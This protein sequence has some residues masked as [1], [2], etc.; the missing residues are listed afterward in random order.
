[1]VK[2]DIDFLPM[3]SP[4]LKFIGWHKPAIELIADE[5]FALQQSEP[6]D[7]CRATVVVPTAASKRR[8]KEYMAE[9]AKGQAL[10][11]PEITLVSSLLSG[12]EAKAATELETQS[13]WLWVLLNL[14]KTE[15]TEEKLAS[16][17]SPWAP[18]FPVAPKG[19]LL[20]W[21]ET[22]ATQLRTFR[23]RLEQEMVADAYGE[24]LQNLARRSQL[25]NEEKWQH[26]FEK[27]GE[28]RELIQ[29]LFTL[30]D[31]R[32]HTTTE[33]WTQEEARAALLKAP[34]YKSKLIIFACV[35]EVSPQT[36]AF[37]T[38]LAAAGTKIV[39]WVNADDSVQA[40][41]DRFGQP[42]LTLTEEEK[43]EGKDTPYWLREAIEI[44]NALNSTHP[45]LHVTQDARTLGLETVKLA[46]GLSPEQVSVISCDESM[47][48][49]LSAAFADGAD[50][51]AWTVFAPAG[52]QQNAAAAACLP[53]QLL[54]AVQAQQALPLYYEET[55][56]L[57]N[58][59]PAPLSEFEPLLRNKLMQWCF[60]AT[61]HYIEPLREVPTDFIPIHM[62]YCLDKVC[63]KLL[64]ASLQE[65]ERQLGN[66]YRMARYAD[67]KGSL[68]NESYK[69]FVQWVA[70]YLSALAAPES[71]IPGIEKLIQ[72][73]FRVSQTEIAP[74]EIKIQ[75][76]KL[77]THLYAVKKH[78]SAVALPPLTALALLLHLVRHEAQHSVQPI[79]PK[80]E[81][82]LDIPDWKEAAYTRGDRLI[83]TGM[84]NHTV[85]E[86]P[87][88]DAYLPESLRCEIGMTSARSREA[89]DAFLLTALL[90]SRAAGEVH[91]VLAHQQ[92]DGTP[93]APST[94]LLRCGEHHEELAQRA[95]YLFGEVP[96][97]PPADLYEKWVP[98]TSSP[99][100]GEKETIEMLGKTRED[101]PYSSPQKTFSPSAINTFLNCPLRFW[102]KEL[103]SLSPSDTY[104][105]DKVDLDAREYG[106]EMHDVLQ[107][108]VEKYRSA[109]DIK[110]KLPPLSLTHATLYEVQDRLGD[111][112]ER[113]ITEALHKKF[114]QPLSFPLKAQLDLLCA[115]LRYVAALHAKDL[116]DGWVNVF[117]EL[118]LTPELPLEGDEPPARF[119]MKADR[120]DYN[121]LTN[122]WRIIDY[123]SNDKAPDKTHYAKID[124]ESAYVELMETEALLMAEEDK[125][126]NAKDT[127]YRWTNLQLPLYAYGL[128]CL[129]QG[130]PTEKKSREAWDEAQQRCPEILATLT[131][132]VLPELCY[133]N[134]PKN[135]IDATL[136][137]LHS[138]RK[139][140]NSFP[141][142]MREDGLDNALKWV[143]KLCLMMRRGEC[144]YSA[145]SLGI[146]AKGGDFE[147]L[148]PSQDPRS[149]CGL[150]VS[151]KQH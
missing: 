31:E 9:T 38:A 32:I 90:H 42:L 70:K 75:A 11:M 41:F 29:T 127:F 151:S 17:D 126:G 20:S 95:A 145:E 64:P 120:I 21:A 12:N 92:A 25:N 49:A 147:N 149:M 150:P 83:I 33:K 103:F 72:A 84:H 76:K 40:C 143:K 89:R 14:A 67:I 85:P 47:D 63:Q 132:D 22:T 97:T 68:Y 133:F 35:P 121:T 86:R 2:R 101:N 146:T 87:Q 58:N 65:L 80:Q 118:P 48:A 148:S 66:E 7:F 112:I 30:V 140:G 105:E 102:L 43:A 131:K 57:E 19:N 26:H 123:K 138:R 55:N 137:H 61:Q 135:K 94:L 52:R 108:F 113:N 119:Y 27:M 5:L 34:A 88:G 117:C 4:S 99:C 106:N 139:A 144:L 15:L 128:R 13:A 45:T 134:I 82:H 109:Q 37:L 23:G 62:D 111:E 69:I 71:Y 122:Q 10:L 104:Q 116:L 24:T 142:P 77:A 60:A 51:G 3:K 114:G 59:K 125:D 39:F 73:L 136:S 98:V 44:P 1:M 6:K 46:S 96:E 74:A 93:I 115:N 130:A 141:Y 78:T 129:A 28:R 18:L 81:T 91:F 54:R 56:T 50:E 36:R 53:A 100:N 110:E 124:K 79:L 8:L 107:K 16:V